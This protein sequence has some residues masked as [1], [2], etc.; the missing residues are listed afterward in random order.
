MKP[1]VKWIIACVYSI[2]IFIFTPY[3]P[4]LIRAASSQWSKSS[5]ANFVLGVE[6]IIAFTILFLTIGFFIY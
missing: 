1:S 2:C 6:I 4:K 3:L 5:V